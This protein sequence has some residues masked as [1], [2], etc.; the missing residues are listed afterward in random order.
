RAGHERHE[1]DRTGGG[2]RERQQHH[3]THD[4]QD[5]AAVHPH[6]EPRRG[7]VAQSQYAEVAPLRQH[8]RDEHEAGGREGRHGVPGGAVQAAGAPAHRGLQVPGG[9]AGQEVG[10]DAGEHGG[11]ADADEDEP[12]AGEPTLVRQQVDRQGGHEGPGHRHQRYDATTGAEDDDGGDG[13]GAGAGADADDV[14]RAERVAQHGLEG[15]AGHAEGE[16]GEQSQG[17]AGQA[18]LTDGEGGPRDGLAEYDP[19]H[20]D[21]TV[22]GVAD[23]RGD[24]EDGDDRDRQDHGDQ[25]PATLP[26]AAAGDDVPDGGG[27]GAGGGMS[28]H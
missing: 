22:E 15:D 24:G 27:A 1:R 28:L 2:G 19:Q 13:G 20:L 4:E 16:S 25:G 8:D 23:H 12:G 26:G 17:G 5:A 14:G 21:R 11:H 7:V 18:Q 9:G 10:D 3:G 6:A